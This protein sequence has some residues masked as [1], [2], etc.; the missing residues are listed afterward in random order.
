[1]KQVIKEHI[2]AAFPKV[3]IGSFLFAL[4]A[5][6]SEIKKALPE[7]F[8]SKVN[9]EP[10]LLPFLLILLIS[11]ML[12]CVVV[13]L[14]FSGDKL[15]AKHGIYWDKKGHPYCP[16][17]KSLIRFR[18][19]DSAEHESNYYCMKCQKSGFAD[20]KHTGRMYE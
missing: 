11:A 12:L 17:C 18:E 20:G 1:M 6:S 8:L 14:L 3:L 13:C 7:D 15:Y 10:W 19:Y 9:E 4:G 5:L 2:S 16:A